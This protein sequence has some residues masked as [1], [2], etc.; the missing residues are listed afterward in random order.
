MAIVQPV[1]DELVFFQNLMTSGTPCKPNQRGVFVK[2]K[3]EKL[4][5]ILFHVHLL[6]MTLFPVIYSLVGAI[7]ARAEIAETLSFMERGT[8]A[9]G[10]PAYTNIDVD[11][12][13]ASP[14]DMMVFQSEVIDS[15]TKEAVGHDSGW[16]VRTWTSREASE[17]LYLTLRGQ[18]PCR[19][20][21][22]RLESVIL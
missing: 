20:R 18:I 22:D 8:R 9:D 1:D 11:P 12:P 10:S 19:Y 4:H 17:C 6:P 15:A 7:P 13:G 21:A 2:S 14:G 16:C 5:S 3:L